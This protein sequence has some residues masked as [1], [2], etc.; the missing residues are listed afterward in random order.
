LVLMALVFAGFGV[1]A[2]TVKLKDGTVLE[3]DITVEDNATLS[4]YLEFSGGTIT[5]T[6][7]INK[8]DIA[9]IIRWTPEQRAK[10]QEKRDCETLQK[11]HLNPKDSYRVEYYD[12]IIKD[13][14]RAFLT[15]HP[16][17]PH[18]SNVAERVVE[19]KAERDLVAAGNVKFHGRWSP[20]AEVAPL[21]ERERGQQLLQQA[22]V[23]ISQHRFDSAVQRLQWVVQ[24]GR[25]PDLVS[26][27]KPLLASAYQSAVKLLNRQQQQLEGDVSSAQQRVDEARR[28][29]SAAEAS[30]TQATSSGQSLS[31]STRDTQSAPSYQAT[32][33]GS[34]STAQAQ[35]AVN[36]ARNDLDAAQDHLK[37][38]NSLLDVARQ[39]LTTLRSQAPG[40]ATSTTAPQA[41]KVQPA[42]STSAGS[43]DVLVGLVAWVKNNWLTMA[44]I[45]V[46]ILF[47]LSRFIKD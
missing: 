47:L 17:S 43:P 19:W 26:Q 37:Y 39:K 4:I 33:D 23:L 1:H 45:G 25:Q 24:L 21:I 6:R 38:A 3:G 28:A 15:E 7:Q 9:G 46:A 44:V 2:D 11:Y 22:R 12:Q 41:S 40:V 30:L 10:Q 13:V 8:A 14:F 16:D 42:P 31:G 32:V 34:Q 5:Q 36:R 18:A 20:A 27:A 29:L 35:T